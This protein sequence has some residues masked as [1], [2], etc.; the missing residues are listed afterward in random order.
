[1][2]GSTSLKIDASPCESST[3]KHSARK[4]GSHVIFGV[5]NYGHALPAHLRERVFLPFY[6]APSAGEGSHRGLGLGL[7]LAR[8]VVE[9]HG[10]LVR[11]ESGDGGFTEFL[12]ELPTG[13][14]HLPNQELG[15]AQAERYA[16]DLA[17]LMARAGLRPAVN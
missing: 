11:I 12:V 8:R 4:S 3:R 1:M 13:A 16:R 5:R 10:G 14:P 9:M 6:R 2:S 15:L 7:P 17:Q